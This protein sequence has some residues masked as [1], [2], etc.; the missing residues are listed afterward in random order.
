[1]LKVTEKDIEVLK[2]AVVT[3]G[4]KKQLRQLQ[5]ECGE[6]IVAINHAF[7][8]KENASMEL[9]AEFCDVYIMMW[10]IFL[11]AKCPTDF[12]QMLEIK[13]Y[14]LQLRLQKEGAK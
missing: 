9:C 3:Y 13:M 5:E 10:Q 2:E 14:N 8:G 4:T 11:A 7:R 6:L 1:M 12:Q